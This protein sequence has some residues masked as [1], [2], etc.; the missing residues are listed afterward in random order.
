VL[1]RLRR[2]AAALGAVLLVPALAACGGSSG[3]DSSTDSKP[4]ASADASASPGL[5]AV[6]FTGDVGKS[7]T[8]KWHTT[9]DAPK[10]TTATT[11]V[12]GSG[13]KIAVGDTVSA[14]L[15]LGDGTTK[16][17]AFSDY[18]SGSP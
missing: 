8:A 5:T 12:T 4:T 17:D 13:P 18:T 11:L 10:S 7:L 15:Y 6:T 1:R 3:K 16:K 2:P 9:L 14:Y